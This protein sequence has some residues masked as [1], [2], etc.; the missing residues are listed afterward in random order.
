MI[1]QKR[2]Q[3]AFQVHVVSKSEHLDERISSSPFGWHRPGIVSKRAGRPTR[4]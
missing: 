1:A 4:R 3:V 2:M